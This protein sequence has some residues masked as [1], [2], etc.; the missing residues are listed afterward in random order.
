[1]LQVAKSP[2]F[3]QQRLF[4]AI[5]DGGY[6]YNFAKEV[7]EPFSVPEA[8]AYLKRLPRPAKVKAAEYIWRAPEFISTPLRA[9]VE[10]EPWFHEGGS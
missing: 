3:S 4:E 10:T 2:I 8:L 1:V 9:A 6:R 7:K 5:N